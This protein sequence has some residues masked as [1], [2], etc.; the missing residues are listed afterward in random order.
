MRRFSKVSALMLLAA[1]APV[2]AQAEEANYVTIAGIRSATVAPGGMG[3]VALSWSNKRDFGGGNY[4]PPS[5]DLGFWDRTDGSIA[6][7]FGLGDAETGIGGQVTATITSLTDDFGDSGYLTLKAA[8]RLRG[9]A[10]PMYLGV[11][12]DHLAGWGDAEAPDESL[13][14][15][16][17]AFPKANIG[18]VDRRLMLTLGAGSHIRNNNADPGVYL[19]AGM[20]LSD[21]WAASLAWTGEDV[22][23][24]TGFRLD[25]V[26]NVQFTA[27][28]EDA[29]DQND[30]RR[31]TLQV[32]FT[33]DDLF[34]GSF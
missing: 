19:G 14:L 15:T 28:V 22:T 20:A 6:L 30:A 23:I 3:F 26:P 8:T 9:S 10:T 2:G 17:T 21:S 33:A 11:T 25:A 24:G 32:T 18:G 7:G 12:A 16:F 27:S 1:L 31:F 29:F 4:D 5:G 13:D 34:G